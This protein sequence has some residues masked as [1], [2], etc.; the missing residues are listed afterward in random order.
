MGPH[1][2]EKLFAQQKKLS[3]EGK[4]HLL[5]GRRYLQIIYLIKG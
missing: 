3:S 2:S 5:K 1:Q 4:G